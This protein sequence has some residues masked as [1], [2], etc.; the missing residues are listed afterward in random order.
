MCQIGAFAE[1]FAARMR[2][3]GAMM[4]L[5]AAMAEL[6]AAMVERFAAMVERFAAMAE[7]FG[8]EDRSAGYGISTRT[9]RI[10]ATTSGANESGG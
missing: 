7:R 1:L 5:F 6:F 2:Q 3:I 8:E 10:T 4:E 9:S